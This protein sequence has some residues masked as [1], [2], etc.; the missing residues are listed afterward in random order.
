MIVDIFIH[1]HFNQNLDHPNNM[2]TSLG[3]YW[4]FQYIDQSIDSRFFVLIILNFINFLKKRSFGNLSKIVT[5]ACKENWM[6]FVYIEKFSYQNGA[7]FLAWLHCI[8]HQQPIF[9]C[10]IDIFTFNFFRKLTIK[11]NKDNN[12]FCKHGSASMRS[13]DEFLSYLS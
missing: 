2:E 1:E 5:C 4:F 9:A 12:L 10:K 13:I 8:H 7:I 6:H 11:Q 3:L